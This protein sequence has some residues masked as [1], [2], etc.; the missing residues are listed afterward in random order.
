MISEVSL[1]KKFA[2]E[3]KQKRYNDTDDDRSCDR[4]V[5][6]EVL[7]FVGDITRQFAKI[8]R[9]TVVKKKNDTYNDD[10]DTDKDNAFSYFCH[11]HSLFFL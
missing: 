10:N 6:R 8:K 3:I 2:K 11:I 9:E 7:F 4:E 1:F 5:K